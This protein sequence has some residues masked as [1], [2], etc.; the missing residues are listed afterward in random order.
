[1]DRAL[2]EW[3]I[4]GLISGL[5]LDVYYLNI[6]VLLI[7]FLES[8]GQYGKIWHSSKR[9]WNT[10]GRLFK[11]HVAYCMV[12]LLVFSPTLVTRKIIYGNPLDLGYAHEWTSRP[13]LLQVLF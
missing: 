12:L 6:A 11:A 1:R 5:M 2:A 4:L 3:V 10:I 7:P 8:A 13:A 9:D